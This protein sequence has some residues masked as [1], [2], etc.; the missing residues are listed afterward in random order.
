LSA[1]NSSIKN[2]TETYLRELYTIKGEISS[3]PQSV[4]SFDEISK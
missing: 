2:Q 3:L 1:K 4:D